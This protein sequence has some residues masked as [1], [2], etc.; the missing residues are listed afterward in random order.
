MR[1]LED[2][3][4]RS[5]QSPSNLSGATNSELIRSDGKAPAFGLGKRN[6]NAVS[7]SYS[8]QKS[9]GENDSRRIQKTSCD[10]RE[11]LEVTA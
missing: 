10:D 8:S 5:S 11:A 1:L 7:Q 2:T 6:A 4:E 3:I 9:A